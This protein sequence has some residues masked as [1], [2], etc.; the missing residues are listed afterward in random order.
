MSK[1]IHIISDLRGIDFCS[2]MMNAE[3]FEE[4]VLSLTEKHWL[5]VIWK[6]FHTFNKVNEFTGLLMLAESHF[7]VHT[8]PEKDLITIDIFVCWALNDNRENA[9]AFYQDLLEYLKP[10]QIKENFIDRS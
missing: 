5:K 8:W 1:G 7:S 3:I 9:K 2:F 10:E 4:L 6:M